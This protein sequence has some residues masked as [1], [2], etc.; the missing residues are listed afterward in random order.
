[1]RRTEQA[2]IANDGTTFEIKPGERLEE[3]IVLING[4]AH[5]DLKTLDEFIEHIKRR[6]ME[7]I[8]TEGKEALA[9]LGG[10]RQHIGFD[11]GSPEGDRM[12]A[13]CARCHT[14]MMKIA[15]DRYQCLECGFTVTVML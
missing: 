9:V 12:V 8:L 15:K 10:N 7:T 1:M 6:M 11:V 3:S 4:L 13:K 2:Y 5:V 14:E